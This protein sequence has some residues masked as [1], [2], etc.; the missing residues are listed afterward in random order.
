MEMEYIFAITDGKERYKVESLVDGSCR[1]ER[2]KE[3]AY[4]SIAYFMVRGHRFVQ[5]TDTR[6]GKIVEWDLA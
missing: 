2:D 1:W 5:V 3:G 6:T 4:K